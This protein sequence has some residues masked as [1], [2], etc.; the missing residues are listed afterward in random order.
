MLGAHE[1]ARLHAGLCSF[2]AAAGC[3]AAV[4]TCGA[5]IAH[6]PAQR[7]LQG[8]GRASAAH[9]HH[10]FA[11]RRIAETLHHVVAE[12]VGEQDHHADSARQR[13]GPALMRRVAPADV[14]RD[15][16]AEAVQHIRN[17]A[18]AIGAD[19]QSIHASLPVKNNSHP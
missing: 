19:E 14:C 10:P 5:G 2:A 7:L 6:P 13:R 8:A 15:A 4:R 11:A 3:L 9:E 17:V 1:K 18:E 12:E 16:D